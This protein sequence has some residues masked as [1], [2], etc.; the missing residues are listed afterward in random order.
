[1]IMRNLRELHCLINVF[2]NSQNHFIFGIKL[3]VI[4]SAIVMIPFGIR[5]YQSELTASVISIMIGVYEIIAYIVMYNRAFAI[6]TKVKAHKRKVLLQQAVLMGGN[7]CT[8]RLP[9]RSAHHE[10]TKVVRSIPSLAIEV[11]TF[12]HLQ[13]ASTPE[14]MDF[15]AKQMAALLISLRTLG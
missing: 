1:M 6:P 13:R 4:A 11:G 5:C 9:V 12:H 14:F 2:N 3:Y 8:L 15:V 7:I 10:L